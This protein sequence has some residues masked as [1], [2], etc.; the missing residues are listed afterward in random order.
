MGMIG[1]SVPGV[2]QAN[3]IALQGI[4]RRAGRLAS[5]VSV[6]NG[7]SAFLPVSRQDA[8][9]VSE[10]DTHQRGCLIQCHVL[11]Q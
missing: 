3:D 5:T 4:G 7:G 2:D 11:S 8:P 1:S 10:A 6:S 9:S